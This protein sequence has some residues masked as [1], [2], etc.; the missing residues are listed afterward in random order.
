MIFA[1]SPARTLLAAL[2][3]GALGGVLAAGCSDAAAPTVELGKVTAGEVAQTV[4]APVTIAPQAQVAVA[5]PVSGTVGELLVADGDQVTAGEPL[6]RLSSDGVDL[7]IAQ[8]QAAVDAAGALSS[9][10][11][12]IDLSPLLAAVRSQMEAVV[13]P[14][15][16]TLGDQV[17]ALPEGP[18]RDTAL[19][20]IADAQAGYE[21]ARGQ[22][23]DAEAQ[24]HATAKQ[25]TASQRAAAEAQRTQAELALKAAEQQ[26]DALTVTA[27]ADGIVEL[28]RAAPAGGAGGASALGRGL[29]GAG[30]V[31]SLLGGA[32][33]GSGDG[34]PL[35]AG[36]TVTGGQTLATVFDL[37]SFHGTA[38][39]DEI[40]AVLVADGQPATVR[41]DALPDTVF[42]GAVEH[43]AIEP[44]QGQAGGVVYPV[45]VSLGAVGADV[46][47]RVGLTGSVEIEVRRV[48]SDT[49]VPAAALR[50]RDGQQVVFVARDGRAVEVPVE[51]QASG[52]DR[53][54]VTGDLRT[55]DQVVT[56][57]VEQLTDG[58][59]LP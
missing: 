49:T 35:T 23:K 51:V 40:D 4:A 17:G 57:G 26:S 38:S 46:P 12:G 59:P 42:D 19:Q 21:Q 6:L 5:A 16:A 11:A 47:L 52:E 54:A 30:D 48:S 43:I 18:A 37:S 36:A 55:G 34:G 10:G 25:A 45:R 1:R 53:T 50:Q 41:L 28:G 7:Q 24:A 56:S 33:G 39:V 2:V 22:L 14:L 9:A 15:L 13:P 8:A 44:D 58:D 20:R 31:S 32:T 27:P 29:A 3:V